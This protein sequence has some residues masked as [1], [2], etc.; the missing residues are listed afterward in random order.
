MSY[1]S[2]L[3][4]LTQLKSEQQK[5]N[6]LLNQLR[7]ISEQ[8]D[9]RVFQLLSSIG[10]KHWNDIQIGG[11][12]TD[13]HQKVRIT[14]KF[15]PEPDSWDIGKLWLE[16]GVVIGYFTQKI[17]YKSWTH[18]INGFL[19]LEGWEYIPHDNPE[20]NESDQ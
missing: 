15:L 19:K 18:P 1:Q 3:N 11:Y 10:E 5:I 20:S 7:G 2:E 8:V 12:F 9:D 16:T 6:T 13:G 4:L 14:G 17:I